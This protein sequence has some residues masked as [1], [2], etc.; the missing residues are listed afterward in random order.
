MFLLYSTDVLK[1]YPTKKKHLIFRAKNQFLPIQHYS[2]SELYQSTY[3]CVET[4]MT[5]HFNRLRFGKFCVIVA[6]NL[7]KTNKQR[8]F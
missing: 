3:C 5:I 6:F 4:V 7:C 2:I 1:Y 8:A